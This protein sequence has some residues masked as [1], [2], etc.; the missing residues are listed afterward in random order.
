MNVG[1]GAGTAGGGAGRGAGTEKIWG[2]ELQ[3]ESLFGVG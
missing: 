3:A 1:R 2:H